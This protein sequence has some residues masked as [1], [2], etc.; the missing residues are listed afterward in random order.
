LILQFIV[1]GALVG[2]VVGATGVGGGSLMTPLLTLVFGIPAQIAVGTDLLFAAVTKSSGAF[3]YARRGQI[4]WPVVRWLA[5]GSLPAAALTLGA[6]ELWQPDAVALGR[7]IR[8]CLGFA[9]ILTAGALAFRAQIQALGASFAARGSTDGVVLATA[10]A[11]L[12]AG[13]AGNVVTQ[14]WRTLAVG[15]LIGTL[16]TLTSVG[17]GAIG[18]VA[19][20]FLYPALPARQLVGADIVHAVPLTLV[21]GLGHA[22]LGTVDWSMLAGLLIGSLP[23]IHLGA[24][25]AGRLPERALR[26]VLGAMLV[27]VGGRLLW[28]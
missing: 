13:L 6:L 16:V 19:L 3:S 5:A 17:A 9:L 1:S 28:V 10:G 27:L 25:V 21:A 12:S 24:A 8:P 15:A 2:F 20:F 7:L 4:P 14:P 22:A 11:P 18:V 26:A 23:A